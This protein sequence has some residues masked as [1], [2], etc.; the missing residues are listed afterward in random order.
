MNTL[1][2]L[3]AFLAALIHVYI[4]AL[5]SLL[6]NK[7]KTRKLFG[8]KDETHFQNTQALAFNQGFYNLFLAIAIVAG[9]AMGDA[10][11]I[12]VR[13]AMASILAAALVLICSNRKMIRAAFIQG[14]PAILYFIFQF[15]K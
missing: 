5:E 8:V 3:F 15:L 11:K 6:W 13:Y 7:T 12:L 4:F 1:S 14:A 2:I 9:F 10:G